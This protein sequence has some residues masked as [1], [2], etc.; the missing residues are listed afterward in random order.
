MTSVVFY[1]ALFIGII[2]L[3]VLIRKK[4]AFEFHH[5]AVPFIWFTAIATLYEYIGTMLLKIDV[6]Y[7]FSIYDFLQ[8]VTL[9]YFFF[10]LL[11]KKYRPLLYGF[12]VF[13][14]VMYIFSL[15][16]FHEILK[17]VAVNAIP[18]FLLVATGC[19]LWFNDLFDKISI[20]NPWKN[21]IFYFISGFAIYYS[22]TFLLFLLSDFILDSD[23]YFSDYWLIN[24]LAVLVLRVFLII[25]TWNMNRA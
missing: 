2:P 15:F 23:L 4:R 13:F 6:V 14:G 1:I 7:W 19:G 9:F 20:A 11:P 10:K 5:P 17:S 21:D 12:L 8:F 24:I 3:L 25:G 16:H 18:V 22:S